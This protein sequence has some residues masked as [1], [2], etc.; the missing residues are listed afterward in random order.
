MWRNVWEK[1]ATSARRKLAGVAL[2]F[3]SLVPGCYPA[4][5]GAGQP[6]ELT[7]VGR[8]ALRFCEST[9]RY[10]AV[11]PTGVYRGAYQFDQV[12][13]D[14]TMRWMTEA[15]YGELDWTT[16]T[17][18]NVDAVPFWVQD[19]AVTWLWNNDPERIHHQRWPVCSGQAFQAMLT[20]P[21]KKVAPLPGLPQAA[22]PFPRFTG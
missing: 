9:H 21:D 5:A 15:A 17:G 14:A 18:W 3:A 4:P 16:W 12:T 22:Y 20:E 13:W 10:D 6:P 2:V 8:E 7:D 19:H 11:S 1:R